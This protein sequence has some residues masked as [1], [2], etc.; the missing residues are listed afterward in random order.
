M[1]VADIVGEAH[2]SRAVARKLRLKYILSS[3]RGL[4]TV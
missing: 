1:T 2:T 3:I 4:E